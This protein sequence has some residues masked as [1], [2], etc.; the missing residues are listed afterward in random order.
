M[1]KGIWIFLFAGFVF[2]YANPVRI[3]PLGDSLTYDDSYADHN[4]QKRPAGLR[5]GYRNYLW[6]LL[7]EDGYSVDF[8]GSRNA[9]ADIIPAFDPDNEGYPG[10]TSDQIADIVYEKLVLSRPDIVLL[11]IGANDWDE[12]VSGVGR[13][14][15]EI[16]RFERN[17]HIHIKVILAKIA[18]RR[19]YYQWMTDFNRNLQHLANNRIA[20]GDD[21]VVVD[22]EYGAGIDYPGDFQD[23]THPNDTGYAKIAKV[24]Y[25]ALKPFMKYPEDDIL[26]YYMGSVLPA[27][28]QTKDLNNTNSGLQK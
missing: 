18:N 22:L 19:E 17:E 12:D 1:K 13:I 15:D 9:G 3:M 5:H 20:D 25:K 7:I 24:W 16:D 23:P 26:D 2:L 28:I 21:I 14:L 6:Y 4:D 11:Y 10:Y 27:V 8:V